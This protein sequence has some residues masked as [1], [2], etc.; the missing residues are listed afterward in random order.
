MTVPKIS[1]VA[2]LCNEAPN[3]APLAKRIAAA[4][5]REKDNLEILLVDDASTD[6]TWNEI[7]AAQK[8]DP[9]VRAF[10]HQHR[11]G[12]SAALWTGFNHSRGSII[13][14]LDGD[15]QNDPADLPQLMAELATSDCVCGVRA[16]R[17]DN[18]VRKISTRVAR[19][20]RRLVLKVDFRD[21]GC[22]LRVF[23]KSV[24]T[25]MPAF[26]GFHRFM[27]VLVH[28]AGAVVKEVMVSHNPRTAGVSKYGVWNRL[29]RGIYDLF[30][31]SW[32]LK[33]MVKPIPVSEH[34]PP[35]SGPQ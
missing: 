14:T 25:N 23:K 9:R 12:Q 21:T 28:G 33:R 3:V 27:P 13:A 11:G 29:G 7:L 10:R 22:N 15:L 20:A 8:A 26:D 35:R 16:K 6:D 31:V 5:Q 32:Y 24:L 2:P 4:F 19:A 34:L 30:A 1:V 17:M 18:T